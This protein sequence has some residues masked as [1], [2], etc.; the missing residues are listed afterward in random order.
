MSLETD[1]HPFASEEFLRRAAPRMLA[2]AR[3]LLGSEDEARDAVQDALAAALRS[4][5]SFEGQSRPETWLHRIVV[6]AAL[7]RLRSRRRRPETS[8]EDLLPHFAD[9]R[10]R[11]PVGSWAESPEALLG[12]KEAERIVRD[13][14]ARL[15]DAHRGIL[16]LRDVEELSTEEAAAALGISRGAAKLRLHRARQALRTLLAPHFEERK[17]PQ[18][19]VM[20]NVAIRQRMFR[21]EPAAAGSRF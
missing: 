12:K 9:G 10:H 4:A 19:L 13:S 7:M 20:Q 5:S 8:L 14:I 18:D 21:L 11:E 6:N 17:A 1:P 16:V 15:P 2:V 3:R